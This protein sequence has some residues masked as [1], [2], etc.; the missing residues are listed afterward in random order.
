VSFSA[1]LYS[2]VPQLRRA[3]VATNPVNAAVQVTPDQV[4][5]VIVHRL[6][7]HGMLVESHHHS[8]PFGSIVVID[9]AGIGPLSARI[10]WHGEIFYGCRLLEPLDQAIIDAKLARANVVWGKFTERELSRRPSAP[11]PMDPLQLCRG[12]HAPSDAVPT[13]GSAW[14][15]DARPALVLGGIA[16]CWLLAAAAILLLR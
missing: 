4:H 15:R 10:A 6:S 11:A 7:P 13:S 9:I 14:T 3:R 16:L 2:P 1:R 12:T 8:M 5:H